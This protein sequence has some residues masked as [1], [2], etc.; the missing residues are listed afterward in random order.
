[1]NRQ[2]HLDWAKERALKYCENGDWVNAWASF[3]SDMSKHDEL[4]NH[5]ALELGAMQVF[6]GLISDT[7]SM[8]HFIEGFN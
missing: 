6:G 7:P 3:V 8:R 1:M 2:E 4:K 5:V